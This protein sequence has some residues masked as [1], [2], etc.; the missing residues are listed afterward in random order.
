M[1]DGPKFDCRHY[2]G[3]RPCVY[4]GACEGC[5]HYAPMGTRILVVKLAAAGDVLRSTAVLP[6]LRAAFEPA[7]VTWVTERPSVTLLRDHPLLDRLATFGFDAWLTL[8]RQVFDLVVCLDK[9]PRAAAFAGSMQA[10]RRSGFGLTEWGTVTAL[11]EG[12]GYD[13][14]LGLSNERKFHENTRSYPAI[15]CDVAGVEYR[16]EPYIMA[17][18]PEDVGRADAF[19][20]ALRLAE[21]VVGL[22]VGAGPVFARKA[23]TAAGYAEVSRRIKKE[24]G[25]SCLV[26][27]GPDDRERM[28]DVLTL[29]GGTATDGGLHELGEF[30]A[31]VGRLDALVTGDTMALHIAVALGVPTVAIFGPT[32]PQEIDLYDRGTKIV[33]GA[34]CAPCYRRSCDIEP[35]CMDAVGADEVFDALRSLISEEA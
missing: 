34:S 6:G 12:A 22:N 28:E 13:L 8:S 29:S 1:S 21:P 18:A 23:W 19:I 16:R 32:V 33:S 7:H 20:E 2:L 27:G 10:K 24:L 14:A 3:D 4:G 26:L 35:S 17:L 30:A 9:D 11:N 5:K 15:V 31:V 25:G